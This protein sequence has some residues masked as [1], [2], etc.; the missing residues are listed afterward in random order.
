MNA[1]QKNLEKVKR[2]GLVIEFI[3]VSSE[4]VKLAAKH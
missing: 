2:N 1:D 4:A 3:E